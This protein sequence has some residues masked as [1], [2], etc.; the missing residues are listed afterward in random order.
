MGLLAIPLIIGGALNFAGNATSVL[1]WLSI[2]PSNLAGLINP[3][4]VSLPDAIKSAV[5]EGI[6]YTAVPTSE[7]LVAKVITRASLDDANSGADM[8]F[9]FSLVSPFKPTGM[10]TIFRG[11]GCRFLG[12]GRGI[13]QDKSGGYIDIVGASCVDERG[14]AYELHAQGAR[15]LGF[16]ANVG[17]FATGT[18]K[19]IQDKG[20]HTLQHAE[21]V[22]L[23]F[24][25][26]VS[27]LLKAGRVR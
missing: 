25:Q 11:D 1:G 5:V 24:D 27:L 16:V 12:K 2:L 4:Q 18:V 21:N 9:L 10:N 22:M 14:T 23:R 7:T 6:N 17:D 13:S 3:H 20:G 26:P 19:L 15:R 8:P